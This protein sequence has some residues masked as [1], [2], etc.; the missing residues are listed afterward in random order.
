MNIV[1]FGTP[2][3]A[4]NI[5]KGLLQK[6][7]NIVCV[8][9]KPDKKQGRSQKL[10]PPAVKALL[11]EEYPQIELLQPEKVSTAEYEAI[12]KKYN[13][14]FFIVVAYG[15]IMKQNIL[16]IPKRACINVHASLLP[17]YRGAA[18]MHR[19]IIN[20][21]VE[22]GVTIMEMVLA[23]DAGDILKVLKTPITLEM[24]VSDLAKKVEKLGV[25]GLLETLDDFE[26]GNVLKVS[27]DESQATYASKITVEECEV[28]W[29]LP[30][31]QIHNLI[32]GVSPFPGAYTYIV[33]GDQKKRLKIKKAKMVSDSS[34]ASAGTILFFDQNGF[35]IKTQDSAIELLEVQLEGKKAMSAFE[36][37]Q[38][39]DKPIL[40]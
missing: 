13:A 19:A 33:M 15:E 9:T 21:E 32:R 24:N 35:I 30:S 28:N 10:L 18:P 38:G 2:Q 7:L 22:S 25:K 20:G 14:D 34:E 8:V 4:A 6:G 1:F 12:L 40:Y 26:N 29:D 36:F 11:N 27:Q 17:K 23:M 37:V 31:L 39:Y 3:I 16:D 5:L